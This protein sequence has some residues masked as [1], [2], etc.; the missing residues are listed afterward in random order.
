VAQFT[1]TAGAS[2]SVPDVIR[3][4]IPILCSSASTLI[5]S[6][7]VPANW[8]AP[9]TWGCNSYTCMDANGNCGTLE[10]KHVQYSL[11]A[12]NQLE[13]K[14][15]NAAL[16]VVNSSTTVLGN[17]ISNFK[18]ALSQDTRMMTVTLTGTKT[19]VV[20]KTLTT[21][22]TRKVLLNNLNG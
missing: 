8:G 13:R 11:N 16:G 6:S 4:S 14:V 5:N 18:V 10:Y 19:S 12:S 17:N 15:L 20:R 2:A 7:G 21:I 22:F 9:L 1:I 3:F